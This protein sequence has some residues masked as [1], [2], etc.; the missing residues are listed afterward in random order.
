[1]SPV[2]ELPW[3]PP[4]PRV[5]YCRCPRHTSPVP[6]GQRVAPDPGPIPSLPAG[7]PAVCGERGSGESVE[8]VDI[9][10]ARDF[11]L[12]NARLLDRYRMDLLMTGSDSAR[13]STVAALRAYQNPDGGYGNALEPDLRT[14]LSQPQPAEYALRV[15]DEFG[16]LP[17]DLVRPLCD[18]LLTVTTDDG[19]VPFVLPS[20]RAHP[21]APWWAT[22]E[23]PPA[24]L[25]PTAAIVG[26]LHK[27]GIEHPWVGPATDF[28]W[29]AIESG[30]EPAE[31]HAFVA[32]FLFLEH[33]PDRARADAAVGRLGERL[34]EEGHVTTDPEAEGYVH[35]PLEFV[36][37][38]TAI[39][40][41]LFDDGV[42]TTSLDALARAQLGDGGWPIAWKPPSAAAETEWRGAVTVSALHT[43]RSWERL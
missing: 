22:D 29:R 31:R 16:R 30:R 41:N 36:P 13:M 34:L 28:C 12:R 24:D 18:W 5:Y 35:T 7:A 38:P 2:R 19:G 37:S 1:M 6:I 14:P 25:N 8:R 11:V 40:R 32:A 3:T 17:P 26:L 27:Y 23:N 10:R 20:A 15:L 21:H 42:L 39:T 43:M 9:G 33:V 4:P